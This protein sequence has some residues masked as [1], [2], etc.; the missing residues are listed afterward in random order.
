M[1]PP[2]FVIGIIRDWNHRTNAR[3]VPQRRHQPAQSR[4][5]RVHPGAAAD[6]GLSRTRGRRR[7]DGRHSNRRHQLRRVKQLAIAK[8]ERRPAKS[9]LG[10]YPYLPAANVETTSAADYLALVSGSRSHQPGAT[11]GAGRSSQSGAPRRLSGGASRASPC[12]AYARKDREN[13]GIAGAVDVGEGR[14][15]RSRA[16][17][18][19][20]QLFESERFLFDQMILSSREA[21]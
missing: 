19:M 20:L 21:L 16:A 11:A 13:L 6:G 18:N 15:R 8:V 10:D 17:R 12:Q 9:D 3:L 14:A 5:P 4:Q 2:R 7:S 1:S